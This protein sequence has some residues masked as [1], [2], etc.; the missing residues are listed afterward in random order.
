MMFM[1]SKNPRR[2]DG[3]RHNCFFE[4]LD[5]SVDDSVIL[6]PFQYTYSIQVVECITYGI[7]AWS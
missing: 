6:V 2:E 3:D 7:K 1:V 5:F 4:T